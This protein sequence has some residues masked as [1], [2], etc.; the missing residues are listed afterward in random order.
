MLGIGGVGKWRIAFF[1]NA[2]VRF[3]FVVFS[4]FCCC[5]VFDFVRDEF[6]GNLCGFGSFLGV[7]VL[8][9]ERRVCGWM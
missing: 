5:C 1:D 9:D 2:R 7:F 4:F 3:G 6:D 8:S